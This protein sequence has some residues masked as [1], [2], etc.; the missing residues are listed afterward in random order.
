MT[1]TI[2][3]FEFRKSFEIDLNSGPN[4]TKLGHFALLCSVEQNGFPTKICKLGQIERCDKT[5]VL[6]DM[7]NDCILQICRLGFQIQVLRNG[8]EKWS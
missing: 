7:L 4:Q 5:A 1:E 8:F 2:W 3:D 6:N